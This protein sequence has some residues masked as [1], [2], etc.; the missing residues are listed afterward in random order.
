MNTQADKTWTAEQL[1][2]MSHALGHAYGSGTKGARAAS[3]DRWTAQRH[4]QASAMQA[5]AYL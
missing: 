3:G 5:Q 4:I 2:Q 1:V